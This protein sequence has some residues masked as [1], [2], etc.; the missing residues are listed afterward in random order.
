MAEEETAAPPLA[1]LEGSE[2]QVGMDAVV[3]LA[4]P[5]EGWAREAAEK[6][7]GGGKAQEKV[8]QPAGK[9]AAAD[10]AMADSPVVAVQVAAVHWEAA[11]RR[12]PVCS[13]R[14]SC[15]QLHRALGT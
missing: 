6:K 11:A 5:R 10:L 7:V 14:C 15:K 13:S 2:V 1:N 12:S 4:V 9:M 3:Q 8:E